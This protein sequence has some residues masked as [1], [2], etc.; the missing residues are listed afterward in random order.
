MTQH[1]ESTTRRIAPRAAKRAAGGCLS[2]KVLDALKVANEHAAAW[3]RSAPGT[4]AREYN[5][6]SYLESALKLH[7]LLSDEVK[8]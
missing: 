8:L 7:E 1:D 5:W 2:Q 6:Q 3:Q 4:Y